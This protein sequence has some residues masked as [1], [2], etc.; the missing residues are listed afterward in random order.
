MLLSLI[1]PLDQFFLVRFRVHSA[2]NSERLREELGQR[3]VR[4]KRF[5]RV[6]RVICW[7]VR[8]GWSWDGFLGWRVFPVSYREGLGR[9]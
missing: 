8:C 4:V 7:L 1:E 6:E 9:L 2:L 5:V 3:R